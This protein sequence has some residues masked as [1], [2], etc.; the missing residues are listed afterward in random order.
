MS[1]DVFA[2]VPLE[3]WWDVEVDAA[4]IL[5]EALDLHPLDEDPAGADGYGRY[6]R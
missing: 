2:Q 5:V 4:L 1:A 6:D 3:D